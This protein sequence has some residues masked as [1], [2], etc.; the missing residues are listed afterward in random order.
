[1]P[2]PQC[3]VEGCENE[4]KRTLSLERAGNAIK[5]AGLSV[6]VR[7][8]RRRAHFCQEHYRSVK[9][10]LKKEREIERMRW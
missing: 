3:D 6:P 2:A 10:H 1:M 7:K 8:K 4:S 5:K 9:K